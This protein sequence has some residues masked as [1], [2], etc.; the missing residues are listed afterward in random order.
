LFLAHRKDL[1][2]LSSFEHQL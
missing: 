1:P 2:L